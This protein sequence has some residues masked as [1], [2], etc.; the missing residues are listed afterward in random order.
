[1]ELV[2][3]ILT[4]QNMRVA[5]VRAARRK[6][7]KLFRKPKSKF[8]WYDFTVRGSRYRGSTQET[9][10]VR[11]LQVASL[12]LASVMERTDPLPRNP[13]VLQMFAARFLE[14]VD[15][16]RL[17]EKTRK[18]YRNGWRLLKATSVA[19]LRIDQITDDRAEQLRFPGSAANANCAL[20]TLRR[21]L[22]KAEEWKVIDHAPKI[23]MMKE[24]GRHLRLDDDAEKKLIAGAMACSWRQR[25]RELFHDIVILMRDTGMRNE[26]ELF[27]M[28]RRVFEI[29]Q[30]RCSARH[31]VGLPKELVLYCAR[32]DYGTR[33]LMRTGNLAAV[34]RTMGHRDVKTAMH[35]QHPELEIVRAALDYRPPTTEAAA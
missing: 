10:S 26:R 15:N 3:T 27:R 33:V 20:R 1:M 19:V 24:H 34:M 11:A 9:R 4:V 7:V 8:Y 6:L 21:M 17:E 35:Y 5:S 29:L 14:W 18:F 32:H 30:H 12:K 2:L 13:A 16:S 25:T 31:K 22:H 28:R 23:K